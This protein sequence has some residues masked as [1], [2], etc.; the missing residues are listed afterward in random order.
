LEND[1]RHI[2]TNSFIHCVLIAKKQ[3]EYSEEKETEQSQQFKCAGTDISYK[4]RTTF[5]NMHNLHLAFFL[6]ISHQH[7]S[8]FFHSY[9]P[10]LVPFHNNKHK[11]NIV[12]ISVQV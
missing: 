1:L 8:L 10:D 11:K 2:Q 7:K 3:H 5:E 4:N 9:T 6:T 12:K